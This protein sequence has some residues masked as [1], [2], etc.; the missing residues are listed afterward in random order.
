MAAELEQQSDIASAG[1]IHNLASSTSADVYKSA[2]LIRQSTRAQRSFMQSTEAPQETHDEVAVIPALALGATQNPSTTMRPGTPKLAKHQTMTMTSLSRSTGRSDKARRAQEQ[3][4]QDM[5]EELD[6]MHEEC[7]TLHEDAKRHQDSYMRRELQWEATLERLKQQLTQLKGEGTHKAAEDTAEGQARQLNTIRELHKEVVAGIDEAMARHAQETDKVDLLT[8]KKLK[9][10]VNVLEQHIVTDKAK[11][12]TEDEIYEQRSAALREELDAMRAAATQFDRLHREAAAEVA[13]LKEAQALEQGQ[14]QLLLKQGAALKRENHLL[15]EDLAAAEA[16]RWLEDLAAAEAELAGW[17][18]TMQRETNALKRIYQPEGH[19]LLDGPS[20]ACLGAEGHSPAREGLNSPQATGLVRKMSRNGDNINKTAAR[21]LPQVALL[22]QKLASEQQRARTAEASLAAQHELRKLL[23]IAVQAVLRTRAQQQ[24]QGSDSRAASR[25]N[26]AV[27]RTSISIPLRPSGQDLAPADSPFS[28]P[29]SA[30]GS[31]ISLSPAG[32]RAGLTSAPR[33]PPFPISASPQPPTGAQT[34]SAEANHMQRADT[35]Q[36][37]S[38]S[39]QGG[40]YGDANDS[41]R[42]SHLQGQ[43]ASLKGSKQRPQSA[44]ASTQSPDL[45]KHISKRPQSATS[46]RQ[47]PFWTGNM[48]PQQEEESHCQLADEGCLQQPHCKTGM[49]QQSVPHDGKTRRRPQSAGQCR[50]SADTQGSRLAQTPGDMS[51]EAHASSH[52]SPLRTVPEDMPA[53]MQAGIDRQTMSAEGRA[54]SLRA[55]RG[56]YSQAGTSEPAR[57][58]ASVTQGT[59]VRQ[60]SSRPSSAQRQKAGKGKKP[61]SLGQP[62]VLNQ[63]QQLDRGDAV[64]IDLSRRIGTSTRGRSTLSEWPGPTADGFHV[65][66]TDQERHQVVEHLM[67]QQQFVSLLNSQACSMQQTPAWP[68]MLPSSISRPASP[69]QQ[70]AF[71]MEQATQSGHP[72][73]VTSL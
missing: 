22:R 15:K 27:L 34:D 65:A 54:G 50:L 72:Q 39:T 69:T 28:R 3:H 67:A 58:A 49:S 30:S 66:L 24:G 46:H 23:Q 17:Y 18:E 35:Y 13:R 68:D 7:A 32:L 42:G 9:G 16:E 63:Q 62:A 11:Q 10:R 12:L 14:A 6:R 64:P 8:L 4:E 26:G 41:A 1:T 31:R 2:S 37:A 53:A 56:M 29:T 43:Q 70:L 52:L 45:A 21:Q 44:K 33:P 19:E 48:Q 40:V 73:V 57:E 55:W 38:G 61:S 47:P 5:L 36:H 59:Q 60:S 20:G 71:A 51:H 25:S